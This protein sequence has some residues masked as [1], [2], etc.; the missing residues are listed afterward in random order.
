M[1]LGPPCDRFRGDVP[2]SWFCK[3]CDCGSTVNQA[4]HLVQ[5]RILAAFD[6]DFAA[7]APETSDNLNSNDCLG[8]ERST[9][10]S[11]GGDREQGL[12]GPE[13]SAY[14]QEVQPYGQW[15]QGL[16]AGCSAE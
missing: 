9:R 3:D 16:K 11:D 10:N 6:F 15:L 14:V 8:Q 2:Q 7:H 4:L 1:S 5:P 13:Q 12:F